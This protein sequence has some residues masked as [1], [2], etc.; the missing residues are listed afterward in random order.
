MPV[1][2]TYALRYGRKEAIVNKMQL[3]VV[4]IVLLAVVIA[5]LT[6][7]VTPLPG[8]VLETLAGL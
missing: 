8:P 7:Q 1:H 6:A 4:V 2:S 5:G 3:L